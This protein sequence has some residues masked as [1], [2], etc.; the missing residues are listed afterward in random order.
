MSERQHPLLFISDL[1]LDDARPDITRA[2]HSFL[3]DVAPEARAL[4]IL[5]DF[6]NVWIGD[7]AA[8]ELA[9]G[10]GDALARL[11]ASGTRVFLMHGNR[12][13]LLGPDF[14]SRCGATLIREPHLLD[15]FGRR[16]LLVHGD[17]LCTRDTDYMAFRGMVRRRD[18]QQSFL[19][20]PGEERRR[21]AQEARAKSKAMSSNKAEDIMDVTPEEVSRVMREH[22]V[23]TLIH[24]H[25]HRPAV[26]E[27]Y[28]GDLPARRIVLGDWDHSGWYLKLS[29]AGEEL[30]SFP[31]KGD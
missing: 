15:C 21:F 5:G 26:H 18:W 23:G 11:A 24:G 20:R 4:Y 12:D 25:T 7:D 22:E 31:L 14:A 17:A 10:I 19:A 1:H 3:E 16:Y 8:T 28:A 13:F 9:R 6:F 27:I 2:L 29:T 30:L